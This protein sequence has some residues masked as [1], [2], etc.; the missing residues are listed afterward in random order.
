MMSSGKSRVKM[1]PP[2]NRDSGDVNFDESWAVLAGAMQ[3]MYRKNASRLS[4]EELYRTAYTL[5]LKKHAEKLYNSFKSFLATHLREMV[6][7]DLRPLAV[8]TNATGSSADSTVALV[9]AAEAKEGGVRFMRSAKT[10]WD[11]HCLCM[12]MISDI[13]MYMDRVYCKELQL[14]LIYDAG[15]ALFRDEVIR[16]SEFAVGEYVYAIILNQIELERGGDKIDTSAIKSVILMLESLTE[17]KIDGETVYSRSFEPKFLRTSAEF[18]AAEAALLARECD[19]SQYLIKTEKRLQEEYARA[20]SY[21][22]VTSE[23]KIISIVE[24]ILITRN[25]INIIQS[26]KSGL[27]F[28]IANDH[29]DD[30]KRL[31]RLC[32]RVDSDNTDL[33]NALMLRIVQQGTEINQTV[34]EEL[35][36]KKGAQNA[37]TA[38]AFKWVEDVLALKEKYDKILNETMEGDH[39]VQT[40]LTNAFS[41]FINNLSRCSEFLSLFIDDHLKK[42][43]KGKTEDEAEAILDRAITLFRYI[44]DKDMFEA[45]YKTHLAKRLLG[46]R[47]ISDDVERMMITKLKLEVGFSFTTK[48]E[49][50]FKDMKLSDDMMQEYRARNDGQDEVDLN[51]SVLTST[52]WPV[53]LSTI[54]LQTCIYPASIEQVKKNFERFYLSRHSGRVLTWNPN[55]GSVDIRVAFRKRKHEL[56]VSTYAMV[57]LML[58]DNVADGDS[59]SYT[60]IKAATLIPDHEL[61]RNLQSLSVVPKTRILVKSPMSKEV[62]DSDRFS[63]NAGFESQYIRIKIPTIAY[64]NKTETETERKDTIDKMDELRRYQTDAAIVRIMKARKTLEHNILVTEVVSQLSRHFRPDTSLIKKRIDAMLEREY[65]ER[66]SENRQVYHYVA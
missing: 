39:R 54:E 40:S 11:D 27:A 49:G 57:I 24:E 47:S 3:E 28:M 17:D 13:L 5:V 20:M 55:M 16:N 19:S 64:I 21:L 12:R 35:K 66:S 6:A 33:R 53:S 42:G 22:S 46:G 9:I 26:E 65:I 8:L 61:V 31:Y 38:A 1:R 2:R 4:Y 52:N 56:N 32:K 10:Q 48:L 60:E 63:F 34:T 59:L 15:L 58:F 43:L 44:A 45:Y 37:A 25:M 51:V 50:M 41:Q 29:M 18:Y 7:N 23:G 14:P 62:K 30:I 36:Q